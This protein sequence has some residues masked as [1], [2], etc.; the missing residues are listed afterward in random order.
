MCAARPHPST[1]DSWAEGEREGEIP[2]AWGH[3]ARGCR[4]RDPQ[5]LWA[6]GSPRGQPQGLG[7]RPAHH[8]VT[9][10]PL[11]GRVVLGRSPPSAARGSYEPWTAYLQ[12]DSA[13]R[14]DTA[15]RRAVDAP[16]CRAGVARSCRDTVQLAGPWRPC[17]RGSC[18]SPAPRSPGHGPVFSP[19]GHSCLTWCRPRSLAGKEWTST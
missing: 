11:P 13:R 3:T 16:T 8:L 14:D 17:P 15:P 7:V 6:P 9:A 19:T 18:L 10:S 2:R 4:D 12:G 5:D 1:P